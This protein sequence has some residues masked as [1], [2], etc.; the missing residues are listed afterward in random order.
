MGVVDLAWTTKVP[1]L[2]V[3]VVLGTYRAAWVVMAMAAKLVH[4]RSRDKALLVR[5]SKEGQCSRTKVLGD[6]NNLLHLVEC[7]LKA[8][9]P[10][11][12]QC[13]QCSNP[14]KLHQA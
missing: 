2:E 14:C 8:V 10:N 5:S 4:R 1:V 3:V 7:N 12:Q 9:C 6:S 11:K 13:S